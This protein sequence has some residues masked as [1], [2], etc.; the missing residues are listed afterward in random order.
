V[1]KR[2]CGEGELREKLANSGSSGWMAVTGGILNVPKYSS[3]HT[4]LAC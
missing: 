1:S 3:L 2:M 4:L